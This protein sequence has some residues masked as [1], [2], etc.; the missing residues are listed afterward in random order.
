MYE[1]CNN[2]LIVGVRMVAATQMQAL[3]AE[4]NKMDS[5]CYLL[6]KMMIIDLIFIIAG[7]GKMFC[8][9]RD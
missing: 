7:G 4:R 8:V 6:M 2:Q 1:R 3:I 5:V 9:F